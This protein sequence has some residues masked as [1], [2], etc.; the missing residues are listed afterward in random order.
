MKIF[1][2]GATGFLGGELLVQLSKRKDI[3][4]IY[5]LVRGFDITDASARLERVFN[6]H[7]D[8]FD[9][10]KIIPVTGNL[11]DEDLTEQL[12]AN[13]ELRQVDTIIHSAANT[14]FSR[15]YNDVVEQVNVE[16]LRKL[17]LWARQL[18]KLSTFLYIGTAT[19]CGKDIKA[20]EIFEHE[21]PNIHVNHLVRY[22]YTKMK[23]ELMLHD[24]LPEEKIL[25]ARPS[26]I[27]GDSRNV[28]PRSPVILWA[29]ATVNALRLCTFNA[30]AQLDIIP[31]DYCSE[32][33]IKLLF[34]KRNHQVYHISAGIQSA[35]TPALIFKVIDQHFQEAPTFKFVH[36]SLLDQMK[37]WSKGAL[38]FNNELFQYPGYLDYWERFFQDKKNLR[39][40]LA[41]LEPYVGFIELEQLFSNKKLLTDTGL[42]AP[43]PAHEY[44]KNSVE[45]IR[46][47]NILEGALES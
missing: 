17:L 36:R 9:R 2:T 31:V 12:V 35:T 34:C 26:I 39:I 47:I 20:R 29:L 44:I 10:A 11:Y 14:S 18:P 46:K 1:L 38:H 30:N 25:V 21:S 6:L 19:I 42:E 43:V 5:C 32:A 40:I 3:S 28:I 7:N 37:K 16:G 24:Y 15:I 33:I 45:Y 4:K 27:M 23:G 22:T 13:K 41:G 8:H